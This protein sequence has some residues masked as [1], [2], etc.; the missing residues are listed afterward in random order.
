MTDGQIDIKIYAAGELVG[1]F[2]G[3]DA[4]NRHGRYV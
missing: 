3:F 1:A 4:V 2:D